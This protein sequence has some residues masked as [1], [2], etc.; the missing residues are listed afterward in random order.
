MLS[1]TNYDDLEGE[2][3]EN[4]RQLLVMRWVMTLTNLSNHFNTDPIPRG[5]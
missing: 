3:D 2:E 1:E 4:K 5:N